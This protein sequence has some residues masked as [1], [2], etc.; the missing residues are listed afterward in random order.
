LQATVD[1]AYAKV[2]LHIT[3]SAPRP[4]TI[5]RSIESSPFLTQLLPLNLSEESREI[6]RLL[7]KIVELCEPV[8]DNEL[9][10]SLYISYIAG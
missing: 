2:E 9:V 5:L 8:C 1:R 4:L 6:K 3:E 7:H 10:P